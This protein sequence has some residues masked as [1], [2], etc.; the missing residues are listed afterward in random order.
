MTFRRGDLLWIRC[1]PSVGV[2]PRKTRTCVV[3]SNDSANADPGWGAVTVVPTRKYVAADAWRPYLVDLRSPRSG[4]PDARFA[5]CSQIMTYDRDRI[6][7]H[8]G[9]LSLEALVDLDRALRLHLSLDESLLEVHERHAAWDAAAGRAEAQRERP[10][11]RRARRT[12]R[13]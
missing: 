11:I 8:A 3:V 2:E 4:L 6:V 9:Q 1:D 5:N 13:E 10:A 12:R 7:K